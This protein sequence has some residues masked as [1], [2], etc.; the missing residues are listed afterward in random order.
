MRSRRGGPGTQRPHVVGA[1][2]R[3]RILDRRRAR[4]APELADR[5]VLV[6][7]HP[8]SKRRLDG[9]DLVRAVAE[10]RGRHHRNVGAD[11]E[12]LDD[13]GRGADPGGGGQGC[14]RAELG[15]QDRDPAHWQ[16]Q[17]PGL[18]QVEPGDDLERVEI[19]V[20]LVET[21]EQD[22]PVRPGIDDVARD[23]RHRGVVGTELDRQR[24]AD[25]RPDRGDQRQVR[26]LDVGRRPGRVRGHVVEVE[27]ERVRAGVLHELCVADPATGAGGVEA[28]D[29]RDGRLGLDLSKPG[30]VAV[31]G[32]GERLDVREVVER[33]GE[34]VRAG[35]ERPVDLDLLE[36]DLLL[37]ERWQDD[38]R[39]PRLLE[40]AGGCGLAGQRRRR[41][42]DRRTE[43]ETQV[44]GAQIDGHSTSPFAAAAESAIIG[45]AVTSSGVPP[46]IVVAESASGGSSAWVPGSIGGRCGTLRCIAAS[47]S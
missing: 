34:A 12:R 47:C 36:D 39:R 26:R 30:Q 7:G 9:A 42:D 27:L 31:P 46:A 10:D 44:P 20:R 6:L 3:R 17:L 4:A 23:V 1:L 13:V 37:E 21:V 41:G 22:Q 11:H 40:Q 45:S 16:A 8:G 28:G 2:E 18:A 29:D 15:S 32:S 24:D 35:L 33:L 38:R 5:L 14:V 19:E 43:V 25:G